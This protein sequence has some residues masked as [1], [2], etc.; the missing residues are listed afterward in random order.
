MSW[1]AWVKKI[2]ATPARQKV[3]P[4]PPMSS[5]VLRP[6]LSISDM[7]TSV[8]TRFM[9]PMATDCMSPEILLKPAMPKM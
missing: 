3:M 1:C 5:S 7:P 8:A 9:A 6:S 4:T 2:T